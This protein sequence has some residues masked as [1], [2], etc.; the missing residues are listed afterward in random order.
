MKQEKSASLRRSSP[1]NISPP[2]CGKQ[3][4]IGWKSRPNRRPAIFSGVSDRAPAALVVRQPARQICSA[5]SLSCNFRRRSR[6]HYFQN[7]GGA[8]GSRL[9]EFPI[10]CIWLRLSS[11]LHPR[12]FSPLWR[13]VVQR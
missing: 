11:H 13:A 8:L 5:R 7:D 12:S 6:R 10:K 4:C 3:R 1:S 9:Y 2:S